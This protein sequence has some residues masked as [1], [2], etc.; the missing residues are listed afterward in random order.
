MFVLRLTTID[1]NIYMIITEKTVI[2]ITGASSGIGAALARLCAEKKA[3]VALLAR[4]LDRLSDLAESLQSYGAEILP[5][6]CDVTDKQSVIDALTQV[7]NK[8]G[9]I[10]VLVNNAGRGYTGSVED[11]TDDHLHSMFSLNVYSLW[12]AVREVLPIMKAKDQGIILTISSVAGTM[13][14]PYN[15]AYVAAKH[16]AVGFHAGLAAE[17]A[18]TNVRTHVICP[19]GVLTEWADVT[20]TMPIGTLFAKGIA[21][22][23]T[24]AREKGIPLAPLAKMKSADDIAQCIIETI[25][26]DNAPLDIFTH[27]GSHERSIAASQDRSAFVRMMLPLYEGMRKAYNELMH[28]ESE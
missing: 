6:Q 20:E 27:E 22:S 21:Y 13:G 10:D 12:Y 23:R 9:N 1:E 3:K 2:V 16:A 24:I 15:S 14:F 17:L 18:G 19:D 4:R 5:I 11:T 7:N 25:E 28:K 26:N 8:L